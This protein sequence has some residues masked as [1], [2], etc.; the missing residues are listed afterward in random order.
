MTIKPL[1]ESVEIITDEQGRK[2]AV[3]DWQV[4]EEIVALLESHF[5]PK[6]ELGRQLWAARFEIVASGTPLLDREALERE[7]AAWD[8][9]SDEALAE[10]E[11]TLHGPSAVWDESFA[12]SPDVLARLAEEARAERQA[13]RTREL[14]PDSL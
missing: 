2:K 12:K 13:G 3:L 7:L 6:T 4:W 1:S 8:V 10:F 9:L 11:E 14:D 5:Q